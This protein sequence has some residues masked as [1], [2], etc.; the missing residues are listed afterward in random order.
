M[1]LTSSQLL[2]RAWESAPAA[3]AIALL[4]LQIAIPWT[5]PNLVTQDGPSHLYSSSAMRDLMLHHKT[6]P[7][8][9]LYTIQRSAIPNWTANVLLAALDSLAGPR[10][11]EKLF[12]SLAMLLGFLAWRYCCGSISPIANAMLQVWFLWMGFYNF[13]L[14]MMLLPFVLGYYARRVARLSWTA[15][16]VVAIGL[17]GLWL[18]HPIPAAIAGMTIGLMAVA[19]APRRDWLKIGI[20]LLPMAALMA[21]YAAAPHETVT[22]QAETARAWREFPM[23]TFQTGVGKYGKPSLLT[24][25]LLCYMGAAALLLRRKEWR[26]PLGAFAAAALASFLLYLFLPDRGLGGSIVKIRFVWCLFLLGSFV[27]WGS[28]RLRMLR[29]PV[30]LFVSFFVAANLLATR[31]AVQD[32]SDAAA[33]YFAA[34]SPISPRATFVR[35]H[36]PT[37]G[38]PA[39]FGYAG[40][41]VDPLFHLDGLV[42]ARRDAVDLSDYEAITKL[43]PL[44]YKS[45]VDAGQQSTLW[46]FEGPG[47]D[48]VASLKWLDENFS[49]PIEY[50]VVVG[51][52]N[53]PE[54]KTRGMHEMLQYLD[55]HGRLIG[56]SPDSL[57]RVYLNSCGANAALPRRC[58]VTP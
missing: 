33:P 37:P 50:V 26:S 49:V 18:T 34:A 41:G 19:G 21:A 22:A 2:R 40:M 47:P 45:S 32:L 4:A 7:Y 3:L 35:L 27:A 54:A 38:A 11:A 39:K 23:H 15:A 14:G 48:G 31:T 57:V 10:Y 28:P 24:T 8:S 16:A 52:A 58:A 55:G 5:V 6:S 20:A 29:T 12:I 46:A 51:D 13:Y 44:V 43:F 56:S 30:A 25:F 53:S 9:R 1:P 42:A 17:A 36:Y